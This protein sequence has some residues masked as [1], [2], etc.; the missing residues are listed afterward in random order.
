M[1]KNQQVLAKGLHMQISKKTPTT[2][3]VP[4]KM[5]MKWTNI[6]QVPTWKGRADIKIAEMLINTKTK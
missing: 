3:L 6:W 2:Q 4:N 1:K 5:N